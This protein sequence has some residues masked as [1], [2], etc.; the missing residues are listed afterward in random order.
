MIVVIDPNKVM[1]HEK[2]QRFYDSLYSVKKATA[3]RNSHGTFGVSAKGH[4][5]D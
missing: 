5:R 2:V 3:L 4:E 1:A